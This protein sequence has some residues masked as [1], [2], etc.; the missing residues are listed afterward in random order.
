M[1]CHVVADTLLKRD[2]EGRLQSTRITLS[3]GSKAARHNAQIQNRCH[4]ASGGRTAARP[5]LSCCTQPADPI[6]KSREANV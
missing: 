2:G 4:G 3:T 6:Y 1:L 5:S